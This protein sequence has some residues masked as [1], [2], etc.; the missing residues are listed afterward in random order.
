MYRKS[1]L[2]KCLTPIFSIAIFFM[3]SEMVFC[4]VGYHP[5]FERHGVDI[6]FWAR[7]AGTFERAVEQLALKASQLTRDVAAYQADLRLFYKLRPNMDI[8]VPFYDLSGMPL[9]GTFP[10]WSIVTD[11]DG[12]R[13]GGGHGAAAPADHGADSLTIAFMG[14]SS[15]FGWGTDYENTV[16]AV[17]E[18]MANV[19][20][21]KKIHCVNYAV[22]GYAMSQQLQILKRMIAEG[23]TPACIVLDATSNCDVPSA[24]TDAVRERKRLSIAGRLRYHLGKL[25]LFNFMESVL[26]PAGA[27]RSPAPA[28]PQLARI[29]LADYDDYLKTF[30]ALARTHHIRLIFTGMCAS[31]KYLEKMSAVA[32]EM[33]IPHL[34]FYDVVS[35]YT[36]DA[37]PI[38]FLKDEKNKYH[39]LYSDDVLGQTPALYLLFPDRCHPNPTGHRVLARELLQLLSDE[40]TRSTP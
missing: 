36:D 19:T 13:Y 21:N 10:D 12:R 23:K 9:N 7:H 35:I 2:I 5:T 37:T 16:A 8:T 40:E 14:G 24:L 4:L 32:E 3:A 26:M 29:P 1:L 28:Q 6:P 20:G 27:Q 17:L 33:G 15:F 18:K 11:A 34:N 25:R 38:P 30:V 39:A 31:R 22:P